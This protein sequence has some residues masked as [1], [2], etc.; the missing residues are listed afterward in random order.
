MVL[1]FAYIS[2]SSFPPWTDIYLARIRLRACV[3]A[4]WN[5]VVARRFFFVFFFT[6]YI[7]VDEHS[8]FKSALARACAREKFVEARQSF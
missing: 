4:R 2:H 5:L 7:D 8:S 6:C 1:A 3:C